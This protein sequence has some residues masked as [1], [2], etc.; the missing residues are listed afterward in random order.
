[1]RAF[2]ASVLIVGAFAADPVLVIS[3]ADR[4]VPFGGVGGIS[5][6]GATSRLLFDYPEPTRSAILDLLW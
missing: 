4:A 2:V 3:D 5:G 1:M 6:G